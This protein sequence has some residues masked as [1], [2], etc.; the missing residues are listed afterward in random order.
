[1]LPAAAAAAVVAL[2]MGHM[3]VQA[4][5][6]ACALLLTVMAVPAQPGAQVEEPAVVLVALQ[7]AMER[8]ALEL[9]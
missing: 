6:E 2:L 9:V 4:E 5:V 1:L 8:V 7:E 3:Q